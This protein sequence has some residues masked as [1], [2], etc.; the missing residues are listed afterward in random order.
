MNCSSEVQVIIPT[1]TASL[2]G[3]CFTNIAAFASV[4]LRRCKIYK[5][6]C[7]GLIKGFKPSFPYGL[8]KINLTVFSG[9]IC[10]SLEADYVFSKGSKGK[11]VQ[12]NQSVPNEEKY[13]F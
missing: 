7:K 1:L 10:S 8:F 5:K 13:I 2:F 11:Q 4:I 12:N 6:Q 9:E 3:F